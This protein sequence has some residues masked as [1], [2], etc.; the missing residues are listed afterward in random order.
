[1]KA[2]TSSSAASLSRAATETM[3]PLGRAFAAPTGM[4][5]GK[6]VEPRDGPMR[7]PLRIQGTETG[8]FPGALPDG[9]G[10]TG[11]FGSRFPGQEMIARHMH[12]PEAEGA[13]LGPANG[14]I[15]RNPLSAPFLADRR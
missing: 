4:M 13:G 15:R 7:A 10:R 2:G 3:R 12:V 11:R 5:P 9:S 14:P 8:V 6:A 1:M